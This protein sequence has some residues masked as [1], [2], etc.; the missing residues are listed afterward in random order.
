MSNLTLNTKNLM[1]IIPYIDAKLINCFVYKNDNVTSVNFTLDVNKDV[2]ERLNL[3]K[4]SHKQRTITKNKTNIE[5]PSNACSM[6]S[7]TYHQNWLDL[8]KKVQEIF[9]IDPGTFIK[10]IHH[11]AFVKVYDE[12]G[13]TLDIKETKK[14][15]LFK[16]Y[17][18]IRE[19]K[20]KSSLK[21]LDN[22]INNYV[23]TLNMH[24]KSRSQ[25]E[26][27]E[28]KKDF[29]ITKDFKA[30]SKLDEK[31][32]YVVLEQYNVMNEDLKPIKYYCGRVRAIYL[33][34]EA[35]RELGFPKFQYPEIRTYKFIHEIVK[36]KHKST[37]KKEENIKESMF[38]CFMKIEFQHEKRTIDY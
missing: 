16:Y 23:I 33:K 22:A 30:N 7:Y 34:Y 27:D 18:I 12:S 29:I 15:T 31:N 2:M 24:K 3:E 9:D 4:S 26:L 19:Q 32:A 38:D 37:E 28:T 5:L 35:F 8:I 10:I 11:K 20:L 6:L 1:D 36:D 14:R 21:N 25:E 13:T 17:T